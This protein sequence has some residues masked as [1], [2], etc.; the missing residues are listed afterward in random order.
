MENTKSRRKNVYYVE[1]KEI[2]LSGN[3]YLKSGDSINY[4]ESIN[5]S[6]EIKTGEIIKICKNIINSQQEYLIYIKGKDN[7]ISLDQFAK[8]NN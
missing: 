7:P 3:K 4:Y 2:N 5:N 1:D 8:I 6:N